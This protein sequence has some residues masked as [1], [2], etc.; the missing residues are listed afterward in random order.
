MLTSTPLGIFHPAVPYPGQV[1]PAT[2]SA[3]TVG[4]VGAVAVVGIL[5]G[6]GV[7]YNRWAYGDWTCM[8]KNCT[9][10]STKRH[11]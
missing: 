1:D 6:I 8:L 2:S 5:V 4:A 11:R 9:Q 10:T 3:S 7:L